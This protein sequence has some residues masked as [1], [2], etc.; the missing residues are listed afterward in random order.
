MVSH[1]NMCFSLHHGIWDN[2]L[3]RSKQRSK[4]AK[5]RVRYK[6]IKLFSQPMPTISV[7][8][9]NEATMTRAYNK[10]VQWKVYAYKSKT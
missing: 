1:T 5:K 8:Y 4:I 10:C 6:F 7:Y 9:N 2:S 3:G